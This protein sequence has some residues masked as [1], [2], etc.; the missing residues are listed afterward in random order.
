[1][2]MRRLQGREAGPGDAAWIGL[3]VVAPGGGTTLA[4]SPLE[5]FYVVI[6]G[7]LEV[8]GVRDGEAH[9]STLGPLDS[10]RIAPG[11]A[12]Q[13]ANRGTRQARVLLVM[14]EPR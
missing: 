1:M 14:A 6:D 5:K 3:S 2:Q 11:E 7:E 13:I 4:A 8:T 9:T 10:C 12:R